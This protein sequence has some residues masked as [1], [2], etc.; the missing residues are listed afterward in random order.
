MVPI[1]K[2]TPET[3]ALGPALK[4]AADLKHRSRGRQQRSDMISEQNFHGKI[5]AD[6][7]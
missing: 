1:H 6:E 5:S 2:G 7:K 3:N 4:T